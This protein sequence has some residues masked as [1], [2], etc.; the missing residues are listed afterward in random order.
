MSIADFK[1]GDVVG[2]RYLIENRLGSGVIGQAYVCR[3]LANRDLRCALKA[4]YPG[5]Q[6]SLTTHAERLSMLARLRHPGL[7]RILDFGILGDDNHS[8][9][10]VEDL[11]EGR[12][13]LDA[14]EERSVPEMVGLLVDVCRTLQF[15]HSRGILHRDLKPGNCLVV[16][17]DRAGMLKM[18][19]YGLADWPQPSE[20]PLT[21]RSVAYLAPEVLLGQA[22]DPR[23]DLYALGVLS[24]EVLVRRLPFDDDDDGYLVQ[25]HLQGQVDLRPVERLEWGPGLM[26]VL[27]ALLEKDVE[28]RPSSAEEVLRL[29]GVAMCRDY[30]R[31]TVEP[32]ESYFSSGRFV[33]RAREMSQLQEA[34]KQVRES[35]RGTTV[36]LMGESGSGKSR[37]MEEFRTWALL[38]GWRVLEASCFPSEGR[39][40]EPYRQLLARTDREYVSDSAVARKE[41]IFRFEEVP[42]ISVKGRFEPISE[43]STGQFRDLLTR[44]LVRRISDR[45]TVLL[46]HD[47]HWADEASTAVLDYL[48]ADIQAHAVVVCV[49]LRGDTPGPIA[50]LVAQCAR[51]LR[52]TSL[53][54]EPLS[55]ES[56]RDFLVGLTRQEELGAVLGPLLHRW[57]G[58]N[59]FFMEEILKH[60]ADRGLLRK[61]PLGWRLEREHMET[62]AVPAGIAQ[63]L[64]DRLSRLSTPARELVCWLAVFNRSVA[65]DLLRAATGHSTEVFESSLTELLA[66][67]VVRSVVA[68]GEE[69]IDFRHALVADVVKQGIARQQW[70]RMHRRIGDILLHSYGDEGHIQELALHYTEARAGQGA[71]DYALR[72]AA[73]YRSEFA[74]EQALRLHEYALR[75]PGT[76]QPA[77]ICDVVIEAS[78]ACC[79]LGTP[80]KAIRLLK[81]HLGRYRCTLTKL[82]SARILLNLCV[83][84]HHAGDMPRCITVS[85]M[86]LHAL[87][88]LP[89]D[90]QVNHLRAGLLTHQ[91]YSALAESKPRKG[92]KIL[93]SVYK[94]TEPNSIQEGRL[95]SLA[96]ALYR[97]QCKLRKAVVT[98]KRSI[99]ILEGVNALQHLPVAYS[100]LGVY[101]TALGR[102]SSALVAHR[103][104][105]C[106]SRQTRSVFHQ[107]QA[108]SNMA[109]CL[110]RS[111]QLNDGLEISAQIMGLAE[112]TGNQDWIRLCQGAVVEL[113][114][115]FGQFDCASEALKKHFKSQSRSLPIYADAQALYYSAYLNAQLGR[116]SAATKCLRLLD[117]T[118]TS[119]AAPYERELGQILSTRLNTAS[120][121]GNAS[122]RTLRKVHAAVLKKGWPYQLCLCKIRL[123]EVLVELG[124]TSSA[125]QYARQAL[126]LA[127]HMPSLLLEAEA[128]LALSKSYLVQSQQTKQATLL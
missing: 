16:E 109:E 115:T 54:L 119:E 8:H 128:R 50:R 1:A 67:H 29:L 56:V 124:V 3:D 72:A 12:N 117:Q 108:L 19:D 48:T 34:A 61:E 62:L 87:S 98:C 10:L 92:L 102:F 104:A 71:V 126:R 86:G 21:A 110:C 46:L 93:D 114:L 40:Y 35:G 28:K 31:T 81:G 112:S 95:Y 2:Q 111:G 118:C 78:D 97:V 37:C 53:S 7:V 22:A 41:V 76:L 55:E 26:Q 27:R 127:R 32:I 17:G 60:L 113:Y 82:D 121:A 106:I 20:V 120:H 66:R 84:Y 45:A 15:L 38:A 103:K 36:F 122:L 125:I 107:A 9:F 69:C 6:R 44:E 33:G 68:H 94:I 11:I 24:Y 5:Q 23:S 42:N 47:F 91:A 80:Q 51:Q 105:V 14:T 13:L 64:G 96:S 59:P 123:S 88:A 116:Y 43:S 49:G 77:Q 58:G 25:K 18:A 99:D 39:S 63:L 83:A 100:H 52:A 4:L 30:V 79:T 89:N 85:K 90:P 74:N 101:L 70:R 73:V 57:S 65:K 75:H